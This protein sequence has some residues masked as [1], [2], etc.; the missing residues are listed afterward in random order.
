MATAIRGQEE[1]W[2]S[3]QQGWAVAL[4]DVEEEVFQPGANAHPSVA[5]ETVTS[6][7]EAPSQIER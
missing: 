2:Q 4:G 1:V 3:A 7:V 5:L 6:G